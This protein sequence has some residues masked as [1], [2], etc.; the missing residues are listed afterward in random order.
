V[1]PGA[2]RGP[3]LRRRRLGRRPLTARPRRAVERG[4]RM[5]R[6]PESP[7]PE[8]APMPAVINFY[9]VN[10]EYG[11]FSNFYPAPI[12][13]AGKTWPTSEHWFQAQKFVGTSAE[14]EMAEKIRAEPSPMKAAILGR[15]RSLPRQADWDA[16]RDDVMRQAVRAKFT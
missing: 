3:A 8:I 7:S 2:G 15:D 9:R 4:R 11:C 1:L 13:M 14:Q 6:R 16:V 12:V 5:P 10:D